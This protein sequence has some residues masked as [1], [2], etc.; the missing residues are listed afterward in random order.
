MRTTT[1]PQAEGIHVPPSWARKVMSI[2]WAAFLVA[3]VQEALVFVV[4]DPHSLQWFGST[5]IDWSVNAIYTVTFL[6]FWATTATAGA[7]ALWLLNPD[8]V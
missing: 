5:P 1:S 7:L 6:L 8:A 4:V 2:L 3:G